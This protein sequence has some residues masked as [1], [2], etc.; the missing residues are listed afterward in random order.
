MRI[1]WRIFAVLVLVAAVAG[2]GFYAYNL[3][4]T[5][6]LVQQGG[7]PSGVAVPPPYPYM[8]GH[9]FFGPGFGFFGCLV[10]FF[11]LFVIFAS[12]RLVFGHGP[13]GWHHHMRHGHWGWR[14]EAGK[15]FP[16]FFEE[17]HRRAHG[18][19]EPQEPEKK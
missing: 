2:L 11:L 7:A 17:W 10:P 14:G 5:Q 1:F 4:L 6:G 3:G 15:G 8:Y 12:M 18:E 9:P 19:P 16:P 13:M